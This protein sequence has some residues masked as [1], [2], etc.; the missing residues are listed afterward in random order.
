MKLGGAFNLQEMKEKLS[1]SNEV[2]DVTLNSLDLLAKLPA[3]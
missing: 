1:L 2:S 3:T